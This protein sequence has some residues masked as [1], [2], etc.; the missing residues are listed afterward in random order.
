MTIVNKYLYVKA[1]GK[2]PKGNKN[3]GFKPCDNRGNI[4]WNEETAYAYNMNFSDAKEWAKDHFSGCYEVYILPY[5][6]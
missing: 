1:Y 3:W 4:S 5:V 6:R 2:L